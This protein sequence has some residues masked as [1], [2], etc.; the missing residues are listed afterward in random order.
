MKLRRLGAV[1]ARTTRQVRALE[2]RVAPGLESSI[3]RIRRTL[4]ER[5]REDHVRLKHILR[6]R[7]A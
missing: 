7:K 5:Q 4:E 2:H 6:K 3:S 1:L